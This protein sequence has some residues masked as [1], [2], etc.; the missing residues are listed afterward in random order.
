MAVT[1][2]DVHCEL[3]TGIHC[4]CPY[5]YYVT[6]IERNDDGKLSFINAPFDVVKFH[7][8]I[9]ITEKLGKTKLILPLS[10]YIPSQFATV[11]VML[12]FL[13]TNGGCCCSSGGGGTPTDFTPFTAIYAPPTL[14][15]GQGDLRSVSV[16]GILFA[17]PRFISIVTDVSSYQRVIFNQWIE[18]DGLMKIYIE[19][20]SG[21]PISL[22]QLTYIINQS[23]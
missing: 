18:A 21:E 17:K 6:G 8:R 19:N 22:P 13:K 23:N 3:R 4:K 1:I 14:Q 2:R 5:E 16:P 11:N 10:D 15:N 20:Q 7:N 9:E 12:D